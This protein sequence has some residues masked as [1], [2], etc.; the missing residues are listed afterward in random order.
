VPGSTHR[1]LLWAFPP[2]CSLIFQPL[3]NAGCSALHL[4]FFGE[5]EPREDKNLDKTSGERLSGRGAAAPASR[6]PSCALGLHQHQLAGAKGRRRQASHQ[7]G[8][9][10]GAEQRPGICPILVHAARLRRCWDQRDEL[11][12]SVPASRRLW[13]GMT[14]TRHKERSEMLKGE[15]YFS[16]PFELAV[17][18]CLLSRCCVSAR[19]DGD[20]PCRRQGVAGLQE[21]ARWPWPCWAACRQRG[22]RPKAPAACPRLRLLQPAALSVP[23]ACQRHSASPGFAMPAPAC[24]GQGGTLTKSVQRC[25]CLLTGAGLCLTGVTR[26]FCSPERG[27]A[28]GCVSCH[29]GAGKRV[30]G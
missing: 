30:L 28:E 23:G 7:C 12:G 2:S 3:L 16:L 29:D 21:G 8:T 24:P 22:L 1:A 5:Q 17:L 11:S 25:Y 9:G 27:K 18:V 15:P 13:R 20:F 6:L 14:R 26:S 10:A 4:P 19:L